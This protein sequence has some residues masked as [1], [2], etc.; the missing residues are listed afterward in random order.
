MLDHLRRSGSYYPSGQVK[1]F[2]HEELIEDAVAVVEKRPV[3]VLIGRVAEAATGSHPDW[4]VGAYRR[5]AEEIMV[6]GRSRHC[7]EA[8][9]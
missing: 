2:L 3:A 1:V 5:Q 6:E 7:S 9:N 4:V 8:I